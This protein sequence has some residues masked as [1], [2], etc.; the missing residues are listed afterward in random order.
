MQR[1]LCLLALL[2]VGTMSLSCSMFHSSS[3][4]TALLAPAAVD[5]IGPEASTV[6]APPPRQDDGPGKG[7]LEHGP[8]GV[9]PLP[10]SATTVLERLQQAENAVASLKKANTALQ[11]QVAK[12]EAEL[13]TL[14]KELQ[15][16]RLAQ[17]AAEKTLSDTATRLQQANQAVARLQQA[18]ADHAALIVNLQEAEKEA[19]RLKEE[20]AQ[21]Q[22]AVVRV[23][24]E[25]VR[26]KIQQVRAELSDAG[27]GL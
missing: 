7:Y 25:L 8:R 18:A 3:S 26:L 19:G 17:E 2:S 21:A 23:K 24:Q 9:L 6:A 22:L 16:A 27:G 20:L 4:P 15:Q 1:K 12:R 13:Q 14:R 11:A 5:E 10:P